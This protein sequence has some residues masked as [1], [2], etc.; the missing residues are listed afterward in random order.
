MPGETTAT[1]AVAT[2]EDTLDEPDETFT[3]TLSSPS[4]ATLGEATATGTIVDNDDLPTLGV[5]DAAATE[6]AP[7]TFTVTLSAAATDDVTATWTASTI[8]GDEEK[9]AAADLESTTGS[10]TVPKGETMATFTVATAEDALDENNETFTVALSS[11]SSN[12]TLAADATTATGTI[13]DDDARPALIIADMSAPEDSNVK[14]TVTLTPAS[15]RTVTVGWGTFLNSGQTAEEEDFTSFP[16]NGFVTF[17]PGQ[18]TAQLQVG[19]VDDALVESD[20]TFE[21]TLGSASNARLED[22]SA[23]GTI[24]D[25]DVAANA[26]PTFTSAA[27]FNPAE[28]QNGPGGGQRR[29]RHHRLRAQRRHGPGVLYRLDVRRATFQAAPNYEDPQDGTP[30]TPM[31]WWCRRPAEDARVMTADQT[32]TVTVMDDDT[33]APGAPDAPSGRR[34]R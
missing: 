26:A 13:T 28:N 11:P 10:V 32:I 15:G 4:N 1:V 14:F 31:W 23:I 21:V 17:P 18:T 33:E 2:I 19:V 34:R 8:E 25:N 30:T 12:A 9:A 24:V 6:G 27:M 7:V 3:L 22:N 5:A 20:E 29:G 16:Q